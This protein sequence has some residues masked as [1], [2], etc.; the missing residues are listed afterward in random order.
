VAAVFI[1]AKE[2]PRMDSDNGNR[3]YSRAQLSLL[4][5]VSIPTI[6]RYLARRELEHY[7]IRGRVLVSDEQV[8]DFKARHL[9]GRSINQSEQPSAT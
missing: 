5:G 1:F 6:D 8:E 3:M 4:L 9:R 7:K 2:V